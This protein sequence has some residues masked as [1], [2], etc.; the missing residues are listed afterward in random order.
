MIPCFIAIIDNINSFINK[1]VESGSLD[2][3]KITFD[4]KSITFYYNTQSLPIEM[5][6]NQ[7]V[8][9]PE[10]IYGI[11]NHHQ[12]MCQKIIIVMDHN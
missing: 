7:Q 11:F 3:I 12:V 1:T 9:Q 5:N 4:T 2:T 10:I 6:E 8:Y